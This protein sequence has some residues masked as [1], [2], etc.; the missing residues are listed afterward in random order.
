MIWIGDFSLIAVAEN[1]PVQLPK[2]ISLLPERRVVASK[3]DVQNTVK[4]LT[5]GNALQPLLQEF[6]GLGEAGRDLGIIF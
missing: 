5:S 1:I 3:D 4:L 6:V 2:M